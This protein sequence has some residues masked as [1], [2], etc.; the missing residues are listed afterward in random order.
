MVVDEPIVLTLASTW[1]WGELIRRWLRL[2]GTDS[3][4]IRPVA[5]CWGKALAQLDA[6]T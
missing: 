5:P 4:S 2:S 3:N 1:T 6:P